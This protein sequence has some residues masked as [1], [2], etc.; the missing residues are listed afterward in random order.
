VYG[1]D[2]QIQDLRIYWA[3]VIGGM[4]KVRIEV[5]E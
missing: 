4:V 1:D 3:P 5:I 2:E